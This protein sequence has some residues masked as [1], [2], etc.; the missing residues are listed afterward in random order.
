MLAFQPSEENKAKKRLSVAERRTLAL[1]A[2]RRPDANT[3]P[4]LQQ[5]KHTGF[6]REGD[7]RSSSTTQRDLSGERS[8]SKQHSSPQNVHH[9]FE[10]VLNHP[11]F[12]LTESL[13]NSSGGIEP[14]A[15]DPV[16]IYSL[17]TE[18]PVNSTPV[19]LPLYGEAPLT[20]NDTRIVS[21]PGTGWG[22][23]ENVSDDFST[24]STS[25]LPS[26]THLRSLN[27]SDTVSTS[28]KEIEEE[29]DEG[30][31]VEEK[32]HLGGWSQLWD[33]YSTSGGLSG[34]RESDGWQE[35]A[36]KEELQPSELDSVQFRHSD[37]ED[38]EDSTSQSE[39]TSTTSGH[40]DSDD[41]G[42]RGEEEKESG[43]GGAQ[44][45]PSLH[46]GLP[47]EGVSGAKRHGLRSVN[48]LIVVSGLKIPQ[49]IISTNY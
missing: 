36:T 39:A 7:Q 46:L 21:S 24:M 19:Q 13:L 30:R 32:V 34:L 43:K 49:N 1:Q 35:R 28:S 48:S 38:E 15:R 31:S 8:S 9:A 47:P 6:L 22:R 3:P 26:T 4:V 23:Q 2:A 17:P 5:W 14:S 29:E 12:D 37:L 42:V 33:T 11:S 41:G 40:G 16:K 27:T 20:I 25:D 44:G 45:I 10:D 18:Q